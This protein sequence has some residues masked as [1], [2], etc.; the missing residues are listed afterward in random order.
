MGRFAPT[1]SGDLHFG[2]LVAAFASAIDC[3]S[4]GGQH[5]IRID[6]IDPPRV[7][8]G[9]A[10]RITQALNDFRVPIDGPICFQS[11]SIGRYQQA[12]Y[13]LIERD[14]VFICTCS[15][16]SLGPNS[17]C[18]AQCRKNRLTTSTPVHEQLKRLV[19]YASVRLDSNSLTRLNGFVVYDCIQAPVC[20][21]NV[22]C[23]GTPVLWRKDGYVSYLLATAI[24]DSDNITDVVRG[25]D[26]WQETASQQLLME[27]L[28]RPIPRWVHVPCAVDNNQQKLGKQTQAPSINGAE[29][30]ILLQKVWRFLGQPPLVCGSLEDFWMNAATAWSLDSV[31]RELAQQID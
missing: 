25:A 13:H 10:D 20:V 6:D 12:L 4:L 9:S 7:V 8:D 2:S 14:A 11:G 17:T 1:P 26:L 28:N 30:L 24:D 18:V 31:P 27:C 22:V 3:K 19:G 29:P 21:E 23:V 15:R 16:K 5:R